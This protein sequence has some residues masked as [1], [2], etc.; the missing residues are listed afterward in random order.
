MKKTVI[1]IC[2]L[3]LLVHHLV[4]AADAPQQQFEKANTLFREKQYTEAANIYQQ[5]ID[6]GYNQ[7][8]LYI[9]AGN[10]WYKANKTG[11]AIYNYE[12]ALR[13]EPFNKSAD[14][15]LSVANQR[16]EGYVN[17]LPL[18]FFQ[19]WWLHIQHFHSVNG[20]ATG[21]IILFWLLTGGLIV[22]LLL[23]AFRP[24]ILRWATGVLAVLFV[25]YLSMGISAYISANSHDEGI[26]MGAAVKVKSAPDEES[27]DMFELHEG[28][29]VLVIDATQEFCKISL[30]DGKT[31]WL[32]CAEIKRL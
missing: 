26:I 27:K 21:A 20:W 31:G 30:P 1:A 4:S 3:L 6:A 18:L 16:V 2:A 9:N 29:K 13:I 8:Q 5:L 23:P 28:V 7:P 24:A 15:N 25:G 17:D 10:A 22:I 19:Q 14:H 12:Q 11:M 32:A